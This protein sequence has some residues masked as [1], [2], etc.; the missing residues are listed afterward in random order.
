[1]LQTIREYA[2]EQLSADSASAA[3]TRSAH[4]AH[5]T[6]WRSISTDSSRTPTAA[7][8]V[9]ALGDELGNLRAAWD[10]WVQQSEGRSSRRTARTAVGLL[11]GAG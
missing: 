5:Y 9:D 11:R 4:A 3:A 10:H 6:R 1:M 7:G 8:V 2:S